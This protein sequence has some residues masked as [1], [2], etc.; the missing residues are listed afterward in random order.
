MLFWASYRGE[1][2]VT[3]YGLEEIYDENG[4]TIGIQTS[5]L[6]R[7]PEGMWPAAGLHKAL[8]PSGKTYQTEEH[9]IKNMQKS[10]ELEVLQNPELEKM[11]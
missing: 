7:F 8:T 1:N 5:E 4:K 2:Y 11:K 3:L 10:Q 6:G 9:M